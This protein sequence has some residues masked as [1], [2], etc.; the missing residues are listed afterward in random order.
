[1]TTSKSCVFIEENKCISWTLA[2]KAN[3]FIG[4]LY[5]KLLSLCSWDM[6]ALQRRDKFCHINMTVEAHLPVLQ[7]WGFLEL[8]SKWKRQKTS[9]VGLELGEHCCILGLTEYAL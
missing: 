6:E 2:V 3:W 9:P 8:L 1:M 5:S 7:V 4:S